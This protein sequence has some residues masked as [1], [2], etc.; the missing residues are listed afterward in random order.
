ML[1]STTG[2]ATGSSRA[3]RTPGE[4]SSPPPAAALDA[5]EGRVPLDGFAHVGGRAHDERIEAA[6]DVAFPA[7]HRGDVRLHRGIAV[8]LRDLRVA[9]GEEC[10]LPFTSTVS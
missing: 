8:G 4:S 9:A 1:A 5:G 3:P 2:G 10:R 6:P 7:R